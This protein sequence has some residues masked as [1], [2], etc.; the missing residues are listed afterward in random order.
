V[1]VGTG[2]AYTPPADAHT[3]S[4][5]ALDAVTGRIVH[6]FQATPNDVWDL[7]SRPAGADFDFGA[8]PNLFSLPDGTAVVGAGQKS[9]V[10]WAVRRSTLTP[11]WSTRVAP[12]SG[13]GGILGSTATD[14]RR[15]YGP[16]SE[17]AEVWALNS[18][19]TVAWLEPNEEPLKWSPLS[20]SNGTAYATSSAGLLQAWDTA[21]G[22][23]R[24][25]VPIAGPA[26]GGVSIAGGSLF[27][28]T[29]TSFGTGGSIQ[30]FAGA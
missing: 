18:G 7:V 11:V 21:T 9:G 6:A 12:G 10:Y 16:A 17:P 26:F 29:G 2:N 23:P 5:L 15:I 1:Y 14:G 28:E 8:S 24:A 30:A 25:A 13:L 19:G 22:A 20:V 4:I 3:D 27:V